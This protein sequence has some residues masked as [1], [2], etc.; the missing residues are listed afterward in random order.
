MEENLVNT[1]S[2]MSYLMSYFKDVTNPY[3]TNEK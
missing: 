2:I 3:V 1:N